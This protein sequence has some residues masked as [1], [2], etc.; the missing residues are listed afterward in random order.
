M[1]LSK[2]CLLTAVAFLFASAAAAQ[3]PALAP[4]DPAE[5]P[6]GKPHS[7]PIAR[8]AGRLLRSSVDEK[9]M[10]SLISDLVK[11]GTRLTLASWDDPKRGPGCARDH[12]VERLN[13]FSKETGGK[14]QVTVD[15]FE[16]TAE[17]TGN[18]PAHL[19]NVYAILPGTDEKLAKTIF[20]VSGHFDSMPSFKDIMNPDLEAPGASS[21]RLFAPR[22]QNR[23]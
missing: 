19:E 9:G 22:Q 21:G 20:I 14:L 8:P 17:R 5:P 10:R 15:K 12:L 4:R 23:A 6:T 11:C 3:T 2:L 7:K 1:T 16:M 18:K 13:A